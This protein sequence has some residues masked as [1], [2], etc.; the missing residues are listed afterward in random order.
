[1]DAAQ[2][3]EKEEPY[4]LLVWSTS[5]DHHYRKQYRSFLNNKKQNFGIP[6][7]TTPVC[8]QRTPNPTTEIPAH[9]FL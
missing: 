1:M 4:L 6:N 2:G 7:F 9:P 8:T 3:V 5:W